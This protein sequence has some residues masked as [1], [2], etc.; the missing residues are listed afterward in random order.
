MLIPF[1]LILSLYQG[2]IILF[3]ALLPSPR[4]LFRLPFPCEATKTHIPASIYS[5]SLEQNK[6]H[7][8]FFT[9]R[10]KITYL[11][12]LAFWSP[13]RRTLKCSNSLCEFGQEKG[14]GA[15]GRLLTHASLSA[16]DWQAHCSSQDQGRRGAWGDRAAETAYPGVFQTRRE[17][18]KQLL[19]RIITGLYKHLREANLGAMK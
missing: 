6:W 17:R 7:K 15:G 3:K 8:M 11:F 10:K 9:E 14:G 19:Y 5:S 1:H 4:R 12:L 18:T 16:W 13:W 2:S